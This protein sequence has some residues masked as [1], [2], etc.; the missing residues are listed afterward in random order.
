MRNMAANSACC[1]L[2]WPGNSRRAEGFASA[3]DTLPRDAIFSARVWTRWMSLRPSRMLRCG[4]I[5]ELLFD[6]G[7]EACRCGGE[8]SVSPPRSLALILA[9]AAQAATGGVIVWSDPRRQLHPTAVA[10]AGIDLRRMILLRPRNAAQEISALTECL[11]CKGVERDGYPSQSVVRH[12]SPAIAACR[13]EWRRRGNFPS[14]HVEGIGK[15]LRRRHPLARSA[16]AGRGRLAK[17]DRSN[18]CTVMEDDWGRAYSWRWTVKQVMCVHLRQWPIDR[19]RRRNSELRRKALVV[20]E[21]TAHGQMVRA[22]SPEV[23]PSGAAGNDAGAGSGALCRGLTVAPAEAEKDRR[24]LGSPWLLA[25]AIQ[26]ERGDLAALSD[27][28]RCHGPGNALWQFA[29][30][31]WPGGRGDEAIG[32]ERRRGD[33]ADARRGLGDGGLRGRQSLRGAKSPTVVGNEN[34]LAALS[35]LPPEA[36]RLE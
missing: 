25:D 27:L 7:G 5:H 4:A 28:P 24:A 3:N 2:S 26:P 30:A 22:V 31:G 10:A 1:A 34:L 19:L 21:E 36:L 9:R 33:R 12:R 23:P 20:V 14:A 17:L 15:Q 35:R 11:R 13:G 8:T 16:L 29:L 6:C 18:C 32:P